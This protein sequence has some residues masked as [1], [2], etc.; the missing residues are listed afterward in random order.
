MATPYLLPPSPSTSTISCR[1]S[2]ILHTPSDLSLRPGLSRTHGKPSRRRSVETQEILRIMDPSYLSPQSY[3]SSANPHPTRRLSEDYNC[4]VDAQGHLHDID[5]RPFPTIHPV[6]PHSNGSRLSPTRSHSS[7]LPRPRSPQVPYWETFSVSQPDQPDY[8]G[9]TNEWD[10]SDAILYASR[11]EYTA[12]IQTY[13]YIPS[14]GR[15]HTSSAYERS[16]HRD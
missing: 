5:Y 8:D 15:I 9:E 11:P 14:A 2:T 10:S 1:A 12:D 4:Y 3:F 7:P 13:P 6:S 16:L